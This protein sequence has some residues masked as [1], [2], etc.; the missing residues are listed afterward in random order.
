MTCG[1]WTDE[2]PMCQRDD[3]L[4]PHLFDENGLAKHTEYQLAQIRAA[5]QAAEERKS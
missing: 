4:P 2:A 1:K 5:S 3:N